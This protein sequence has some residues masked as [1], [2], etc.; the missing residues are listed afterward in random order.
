MPIDHTHPRSV[1]P[2][3]D[4]HNFTN[5]QGV[6]LQNRVVSAEKGTTFSS[7][8]DASGTRGVSSRND[9]GGIVGGTI[10]LTPEVVA[11]AELRNGDAM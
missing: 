9:V 7:L 1:Y 10:G 5:Y 6:H 2:G 4:R 8:G 3:S 11:P